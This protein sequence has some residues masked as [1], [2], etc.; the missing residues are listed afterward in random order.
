M[1][2]KMRAIVKTKREKGGEMVQ[3]DVPRIAPDQV[4]VKV[5]ATSICGTDV[6]IYEWN[7]WAQ[8]RIKTIPQTMGHEFAGE[9]VEVGSQVTKSWRLH[10]S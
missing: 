10:L 2:E 9:V 8:G 5:K 3:V 4:L 6:H 1:P 7:E